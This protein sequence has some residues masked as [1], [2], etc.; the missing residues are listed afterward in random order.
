MNVVDNGLHGIGV[1][2]GFS[3]GDGARS[4][5]SVDSRFDDGLAVS[6]DV[7]FSFTFGDAVFIGV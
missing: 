6:I 2:A 1:D 5:V 3:L 7:G 4:S